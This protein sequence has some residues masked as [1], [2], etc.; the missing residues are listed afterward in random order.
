MTHISVHSFL[1]LFRGQTPSEQEE[2]AQKEKK[3]QKII[4]GQHTVKS[5]FDRW[6]SVYVLYF[7]LFKMINIMGI[8]GVTSMHV[9]YWKPQN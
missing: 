8:D 1:Q 4:E 2:T 5:M 6:G 3:N 7:F 9:L